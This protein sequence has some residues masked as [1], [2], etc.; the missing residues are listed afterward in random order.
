[1]RAA[2][3]ELAVPVVEVECGVGVSVG[4]G[5]GVGADLSQIAQICSKNEVSIY[6]PIW[7]RLAG[8]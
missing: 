2:A 6:L 4:V 1:M 8:T 5:V 3:G 7:A